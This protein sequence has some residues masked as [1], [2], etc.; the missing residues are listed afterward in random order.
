M[1]AGRILAAF[2][3]AL[4]RTVPEYDKLDVYFNDDGGSGRFRGVSAGGIRQRA[5]IFK[6]LIEPVK[7][8]HIVAIS[9]ADQFGP[10]TS[11]AGTDSSSFRGSA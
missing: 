8:Q 3:K 4:A 1:E 9:G 2:H 6:S 10:T 7:D 11:P 5:A